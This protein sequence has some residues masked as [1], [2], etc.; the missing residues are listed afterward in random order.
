MRTFEETAWRM[1]EEFFACFLEGAGRPD[2]PTDFASYMAQTAL[3]LIERPDGLVI[4]NEN[5]RGIW[6]DGMLRR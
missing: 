1:A 6:R 3:P 4:Y 2:S 5:A